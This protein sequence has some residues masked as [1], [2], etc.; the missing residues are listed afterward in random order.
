MESIVSG[1]RFTTYNPDKY[2]SKN[3]KIEKL[4]NYPLGEKVV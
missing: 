4:T 3:N 2:L 1:V